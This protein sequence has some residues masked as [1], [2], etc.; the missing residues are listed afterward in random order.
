MYKLNFI[1]IFHSQKHEGHIRSKLKS[2]GYLNSHNNYSNIQLDQQSIKT[3]WSLKWE[4]EQQSSG[5]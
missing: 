5:I 1:N 2:K 3:K 4:H